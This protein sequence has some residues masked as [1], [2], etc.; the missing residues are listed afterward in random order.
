VKANPLIGVLLRA[1]REIGIPGIGS[2]F[3]S[4]RSIEEPF[5]DGA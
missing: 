5:A 4:H 1:D 3:K 2:K